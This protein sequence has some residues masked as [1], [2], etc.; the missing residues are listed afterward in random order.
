MIKNKEIWAKK[1]FM[2]SLFKILTFYFLAL[3]TLGI[4][5]WAFVMTYSIWTIIVGLLVEL[6]L[7]LFRLVKALEKYD[8]DPTIPFAGSVGLTAIVML[9]F[10]ALS[11]PQSENQKESKIHTLMRVQNSEWCNMTENI[12]DRKTY[13]CTNGID[14][15]VRKYTFNYRAGNLLE[16]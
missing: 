15:E 4:W 12:A 2:L 9:I 8:L 14:S 11:L 6:F 13:V 7:I 3:G 16:D 1:E 5:V 10:F